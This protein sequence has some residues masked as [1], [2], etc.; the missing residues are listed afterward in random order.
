MLRFNRRTFLR[1][2]LKA[3]IEFNVLGLPNGQRALMF[4][5]CKGGLHFISD[6]YVEPGATITLS[7]CEALRYYFPV[8]DTCACRATVIWCR[9]HTDQNRRGFKIGVQFVRPDQTN[10]R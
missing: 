3:P 2:Y 5:C 4:D 8:E 7:S 9:R 1:R 6:S 10:G